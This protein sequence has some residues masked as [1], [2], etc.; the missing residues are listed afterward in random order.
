MTFRQTLLLSVAVSTAIAT[1]ASTAASASW[2]EPD[3]AFGR[4]A[5]WYSG[6]PFVKGPGPAFGYGPPSCQ[7][8]EIVYTRRHG[9]T[10]VLRVKG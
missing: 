7:P 3:D 5:C 10:R 1:I 8:R 6:S 9:R 2:R 4:L